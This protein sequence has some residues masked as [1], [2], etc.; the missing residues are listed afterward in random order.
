MSQFFLSL[1]ISNP[2]QK[3]LMGIYLR[4]LALAYLYGA[5]V[6]YANFLGWGEMPW[7]E[8]PRTWQICDICYGILDPLA[9][10]GLWWKKSW[11]IGCFFLGAG[12][13]LILYLGFPD[14]FVLTAEHQQLLWSLIFF[15]L[16]SLVIFFGLLVVERKKMT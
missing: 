9:F 4:L 14:L 13:Q 16:V 15:H 8:M 10:I 1:R 7:L 6:H 12:S 2:G 3:Q 5:S 11:G